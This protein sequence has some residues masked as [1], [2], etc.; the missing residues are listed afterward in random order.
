M[1][2]NVAVKNALVAAV[3]CLLAV[4]SLQFAY[5]ASNA[6]PV[7]PPSGFAFAIL[8]LF[9]RKLTPGIFL[10]AVAANCYVFLDHQ[11]TSTFT[12]IWVSLLIGAGNTLEALFG[13]NVLKLFMAQIVNRSG[14]SGCRR[15][16]SRARAESS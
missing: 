2:L 16:E 8:L 15:K 4:T 9:G 3:Y 5:H 1:T 10:G 13:Y 7:W 14:R 6:T 11:T 12:S